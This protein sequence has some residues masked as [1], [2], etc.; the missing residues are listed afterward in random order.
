MENIVC[1][2]CGYTDSTVRGEGGPG[3]ALLEDITVSRA[4]QGIRDGQ[5]A[6]DSTYH[7]GA[8]YD[9]GLPGTL[10]LECRRCLREFPL[11]AG[12]DIAWE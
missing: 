7:T 5:L 3:F 12:V 6:V 10:R 11:P 8:G 2:H 9:E 1:P 4:V